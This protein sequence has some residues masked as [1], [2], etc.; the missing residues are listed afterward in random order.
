MGGFGKG[1][2]RQ[3]L[4]GEK[5]Q[6]HRRHR[7]SSSQREPRLSFHPVA[8]LEGMRWYDNALKR[9]SE[10]ENANVADLTKTGL[11]FHSPP[12][13]PHLHA[14]APPLAASLRVPP[15]GHSRCALH[16]GLLRTP[17]PATH[18]TPCWPTARLS[19]HLATRR[20]PPT[21]MACS[22]PHPPRRH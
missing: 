22:P 5:Q 6:K 20:P 8:P 1:L 17:L 3:R 18:L 7:P 10:L 11:G 13:I 4:Q 14:I 9:R 2:L 19:R 21:S 16:A 12:T 15:H